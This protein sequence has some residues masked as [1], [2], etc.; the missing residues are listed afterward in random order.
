MGL[1]ID[2]INNE[3]IAGLPEPPEDCRVTNETNDAL[4]VKCRSADEK[5]V[6]F[7]DDVAND[8]LD[9][10]DVANDDPDDVDGDDE[11]SKLLIFC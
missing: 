4:S 7:D 2:Y 5:N 9:D 11:H 10:V 3:M 8:D 1:I 6:T